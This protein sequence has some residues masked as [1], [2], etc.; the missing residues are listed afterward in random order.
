MPFLRSL[1]SLRHDVRYALRTLH[2]SPG[3]TIVAI[4][5]LAIGIG[6]NTAIF[7]LVDAVRAHALPYSDSSQLVVLW[8]TV[9]RARLERRGASYPDYLDWR[10]RSKSFEDIA[11]PTP[12]R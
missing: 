5:A 10:A 9:L 2:K 4:G 3:F 7:S 1:E 11:G 8:G 6:A 12:R